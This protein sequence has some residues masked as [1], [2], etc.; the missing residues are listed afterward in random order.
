MI[1]TKLL[2][3]VCRIPGAPGYEHKIRS[4]IIETLE[5]VADEIEVDALGN[6]VAT[7]KGQGEKTLAVA[8]HMDEISFVVT[9]IDE[10]GF[11]RFQPLG[12]FDP[13]T[14]T[15]Q[16]VI[17]HGRE[18]VMGVM[19]SKP[20]HIMKPEDRKKPPRMEDYFI[21]TGFD[22]ESIE[23]KISV[24]DTVTR[25]RE[26]IEMGPC[27]NAKSLDNRVSVF[28]LLEI[29]R[30]LQGESIPYTLKG[31]F[32]VQE[33][34]GVRGAQVA[35]H[36]LNPD[37]TIA[38]DTTIAFDTP[39]AQA[40]EKVTQ[41]G[42]GTAIKI[43]DGMTICDYRMVDYMKTQAKKHQI[44]WQAE[45][46]P[47]GG[48]DTAAMQRNGRNGSIAGAISIPTRHIHQVIEMVHTQ[49]VANSIE[50][51]SQCIRNIDQFDWAHK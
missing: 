25:E 34:V 46:L 38:L 3:E 27:V 4:F 15:A 32:T 39:G 17:I 20:I 16:R 26:L 45:V 36:H 19:G 43:L 13:K 6:V 33:E 50:L 35:A 14:L 10:D 7:K 11:V 23:S 37:F 44:P 12:G 40:H 22:K 49:D 28:I 18:D 24:G 47:A 29:F 9:H 1:D 30:L 48:T 41:L 42:N 5:D 8:A 31:V 2:A 51:L 21:D